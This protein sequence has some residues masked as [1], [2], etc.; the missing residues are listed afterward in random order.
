[1]RFRL[2]GSHN[3]D[4]QP[5]VTYIYRQQQLKLCMSWGLLSFAPSSRRF[6]FNHAVYDLHS[7]PLSAGSGLRPQVARHCQQ[8]LPF[9]HGCVSSGLPL[10]THNHLIS[11]RSGVA[12]QLAAPS[13]PDL[14]FSAEMLYRRGTKH[15][16]QQS[17]SRLQGAS[18]QDGVCI[19]G[20][21]SPQIQYHACIV[22]G[23]GTFVHTK[24]ASC[25]DLA[26]K[27][28]GVAV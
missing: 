1:M 5:S 28:C 4:L 19:G 24:R 21:R 27:A 7:R 2:T 25:A 16:S 10:R 6:F 20:V 22:F 8:C 17:A 23:R 3:L 12:S 26:S 11:A 15:A 14:C 18:V 9:R 13:S